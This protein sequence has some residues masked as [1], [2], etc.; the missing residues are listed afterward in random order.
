MHNLKTGPWD[1]DFENFL[2]GA[3][4]TDC[5]DGQLEQERRAFQET[6]EYNSSRANDTPPICCTWIANGGAG[7]CTAQW[8]PQPDTATF[9][10]GSTA[11]CDTSGKWNCD[12]CYPPSGPCCSPLVCN[13]GP[14]GGCACSGNC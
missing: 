2:T 13:P 4:P 11:T 7:E 1:I 12:Q 5:D 8:K 6:C 14:F 9:C 10:D 3:N